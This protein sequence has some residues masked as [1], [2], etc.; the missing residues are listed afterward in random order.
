LKRA[1]EGVES[2][3][4]TEAGIDLMNQ[5]SEEEVKPGTTATNDEIDKAVVEAVQKAL[6]EMRRNGTIKKNELGEEDFDPQSIIDNA[7]GEG[8]IDVSKIPAL[9]GIGSE[10]RWR[11]IMR[12]VLKHIIS[13]DE[14]RDPNVI[15]RR[16][17]VEGAMG[18]SVEERKVKNV[19]IMADRSGS[20]KSMHVFQPALE[21]LRDFF[22]SYRAIL[23]SAVVHVFFWGS[24]DRSKYLRLVGFSDTNLKRVLADKFDG[25][26]TDFTFNFV[27]ALTKCHCPD[28]IIQ[29]TDGAFGDTYSETVKNKDFNTVFTPRIRK[30][31]VWV[32]PKGFHGL[33][34][35]EIFKIDPS[36]RERLVLYNMSKEPRVRPIE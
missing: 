33:N 3:H 26:N 23:G 1:K 8:V 9:R 5:V 18:G 22:E 30:R 7:L 4:G 21:A 25:G 29:L 17:E 34:L 28:I 13:V 14:K 35:K 31:T 20:F 24:L 27:A 12:R 32:C 2:R 16:I 6:E 36:A 11:E 10:S 19:L 15:S